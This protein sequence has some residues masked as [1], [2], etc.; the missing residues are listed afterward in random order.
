MIPK[1]HQFNYINAVS[2]SHT[3]DAFNIG[4]QAD[5]GAVFPLKT[6]TPTGPTKAKAMSATAAAVTLRSKE[7]RPAVSDPRHHFQF[8]TRRV[9]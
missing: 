8:S 3:P 1:Q 7:A 4:H 2:V 5:T 6:A 9:K